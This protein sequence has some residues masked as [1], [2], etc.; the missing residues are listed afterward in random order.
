MGVVIVIFL[1]VVIR[2]IFGLPS[3]RRPSTPALYDPHTFTAHRVLT[4]TSLAALTYMGFDGISTLSEEVRDPR[5]NILRA[6][7][8]T[9]VVTGVLASVEVYAAQLVW[10]AGR[11]FGGQPETAY[12]QVGDLISGP[13]WRRWSI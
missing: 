9:C 2:Y 8:L 6:T 13:G 4:G 1:L 10:P 7:V 5:K 3:R 11:G 12:A